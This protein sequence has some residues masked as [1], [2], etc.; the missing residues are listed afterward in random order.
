MP[1]QAASTQ[2]PMRRRLWLNGGSRTPKTAEDG[3][4]VPGRDLPDELPARLD[5]AVEPVGER[6]GLLPRLGA[7]DHV[8]PA[9]D[10]AVALRLEALRKLARL[11][12][13]AAG[14]PHLPGRI[15]RR[16]RLLLDRARR[17]LVV[18]TVVGGEPVLR[19]DGLRLDAQLRAFGVDRLAR[20]L[21]CE[22]RACVDE[23]RPAFE[24]D[25]EP[26]VAE[27]VREPPRVGVEHA[28]PG[29]QAAC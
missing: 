17:G 21:E 16:E 10:D 7:G 2:Y 13:R 28:E 25:C 1:L 4:R 15:P 8:S 20:L 11:V 3:E 19:D 5:L 18:P 26:F 14:D 29:E 22:R 24:R 6:L 12:V 9:A 23:E 27:V